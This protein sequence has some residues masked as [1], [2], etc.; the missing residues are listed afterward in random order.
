MTFSGYFF[1]AICFFSL[2]IAYRIFNKILKQRSEVKGKS[3]FLEKGL[4]L[5][6]ISLM[7]IVL[8]SLTLLLSY[9]FFWEKAYRSISEKHYEA[10]VI[11]YKKETIATRN[12]PTSGYYNKQVYFSKV[13]YLSENGKETI[14]TL[15]LTGNNPPAIGQTLNI[16]ATETGKNANSIE[17]NWIMFAFGSVF[18]GVTAFFACLLITYIQNTTFKK[19]IGISLYGALAIL[20]L[21]IACILLIWL[22]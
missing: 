15:D 20:I 16:T 22:Q 11:G 19:R 13:K 8:H 3:G 9:S 4:M 7:M 17:L 21:N 18:T 6:F 10:V 1:L 12:F 14:R 5:F 2:Y